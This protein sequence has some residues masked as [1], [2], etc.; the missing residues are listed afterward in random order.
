MRSVGKLLALSMPS[1]CISVPMEGTELHTCK[2][3][4]RMKC[5]G[6]INSASGTTHNSPPSDQVV[7]K[8]DT[9]GSNEKS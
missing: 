8:S 6:A 3:L 2:S 7:N 4:R 1:L 9:E 5:A